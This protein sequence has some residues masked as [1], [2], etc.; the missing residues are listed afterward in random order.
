M[1][2][3]EGRNNLERD[4]TGSENALLIRVECGYNTSGIS[5]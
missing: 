5:I 3:K 4:G 1:E 2:T